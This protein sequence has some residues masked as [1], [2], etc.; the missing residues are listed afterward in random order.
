MKSQTNISSIWAK[1]EVTLKGKLV[2][3]L[4]NLSGSLKF[5]YQ[6]KSSFTSTLNENITA[7][8]KLPLPPQVRDKTVIR[9]AITGGW[10]LP[11]NDVTLDTTK[12]P[13]WMPDAYVSKKLIPWC[14][15]WKVI[16]IIYK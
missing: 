14:L 6:T 8:I 13:Y 4:F 7:G 5:S 1:M 3:K 10:S 12:K 16:E 9:L 15:S 2:E 11:Q